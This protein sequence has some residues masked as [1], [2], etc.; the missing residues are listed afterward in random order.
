MTKLP[1]LLASAEAVFAEDDSVV[2]AA[3]EVCHHLCCSQYL[4]LPAAKYLTSCDLMQAQRIANSADATGAQL[5]KALSGKVAVIPQHLLVAP[6]TCSLKWSP[7][8]SHTQLS[9]HQQPERGST[10]GA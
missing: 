3:F 8:C 9:D 1:A 5:L 2:I 7:L 10:A 4:P 6:V